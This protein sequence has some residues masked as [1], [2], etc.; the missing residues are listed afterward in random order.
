MLYLLWS[1]LLSFPQV[2]IDDEEGKGPDPPLPTQEIP[3]PKFPIQNLMGI[4]RKNRERRA[5]AAPIAIFPPQPCNAMITLA[6]KL[7]K[8]V[9]K[10]REPQ[11]QWKTSGDLE[12]PK[13]LHAECP[14]HN[15]KK[16]M[17]SQNITDK[18]A[19]PRAMRMPWKS[20]LGKPVPFSP[21]GKGFENQPS[22]PP[23]EFFL[24]P[25]CAS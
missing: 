24:A 4:T 12:D 17:A 20:R 11:A 10:K 3:R 23:R 5:P 6:A 25:R 13:V 2:S 1:P 18:M 21:I 14:R 9:P 22:T 16:E 7:K 19:H 15:F 8:N